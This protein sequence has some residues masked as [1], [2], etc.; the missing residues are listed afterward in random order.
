MTRSIRK[1]RETK[2][3]DQNGDMVKVVYKDNL[4]D[5]RGLWSK[6]GAKSTP[7]S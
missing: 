3:F 7:A 2:V 5:N 6:K 4:S 1:Y